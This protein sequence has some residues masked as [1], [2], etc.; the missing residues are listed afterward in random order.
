MTVPAVSSTLLTAAGGTLTGGLT[1]GGQ[2]NLGSNGQIVF[3][4]TQNPSSNANT[5]DDYEEGTWTPTIDSWNGTYNLQQG[6]YTK[7]GRQVTVYG[8][9]QT[10]PNSG[11]WN[12][13]TP[14]LLG[15]PFNS[16]SVSGSAINGSWNYASGITGFSS[17]NIGAGNFDGPQNGGTAAF[18]NNFRVGDNIG[19]LTSSNLS[20][21][22][23]C[24]MRF[25]LTYFTA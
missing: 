25:M 13:G 2:L 5:M 22:V 15:L 1:M 23:A 24:Q 12:G 19:N 16:Q 18:P 7:I 20:N 6:F 9:V 14:Q 17:P 4:A 21:S 10:T 8:R 11:S 3:P